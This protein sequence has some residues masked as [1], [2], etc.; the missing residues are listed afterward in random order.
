MDQKYLES[1][2]FYTK[3][4]NNFSTMII[5]PMALIIVV[6]LAFSFW[7]QKEITIAG[8]GTIEPKHAAAVV[9]SSST[10]VIKRNLLHEGKLV[11]R[12]ELL[13]VYNASADQHK[14]QYYKQQQSNLQQ[15]QT[16]LNLLK[17]GISQNQDVFTTDDEYG[18]RAILKD[19]LAQR[20]IVLTQNEQANQQHKDHHQ[21]KKDTDYQLQEN[22]SKLDSLQMQELEKVSQQL[23][24]NRQK[25]QEVAAN[26]DN[27]TDQAK[28]YRIK[29]P[30]SGVL[31][32]NDQYQKAQYIPAGSEVA[33]I[34][35]VLQKQTELQ[36][37]SYVSTADIS[38]VK[39]GQKIR[40]KI[41]RNVPKPV[42]ITGKIKQISVSPVNIDKQQTAYVVTSTAQV[43]PATR[44]L[45]KYG[46]VGSTSI[47]TGKRSFFNYY[48][49]K[50]L[51]QN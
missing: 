32:I 46:M 26:I 3:R 19:Y 25:L 8:M 34:Y 31:H 49:D 39:R 21:S 47:I 29:A 5:I 1:S 24:D 27:L 6:V 4:F 9:Q 23:V 15:Q 33:Q 30:K 44:K 17:Q 51:N 13:L 18:Y 43:S 48:K 20:Q 38:S 11:K 42:I 45:L 37:K 28:T 7:G 35:P 10:N 41:T 14:Q 22:N 36:L 2:E 40:F 50:L 16:S 12:G